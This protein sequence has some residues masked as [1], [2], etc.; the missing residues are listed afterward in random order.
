MSAISYEDVPFEPEYEDY[1]D[2]LSFSEPEDEPE[3]DL[4]IEDRRK[5]NE[6]KEILKVHPFLVRRP[7]KIMSHKHTDEQGWSSYG[8]H[9]KDSIGKIGIVVEVHNTVREAVRVEFPD[10]RDDIYW[11]YK[12]L[13][14]IAPKADDTPP[15]F[16]DPTNLII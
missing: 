2:E 4:N 16:F 8:S 14:L 10:V 13:E 15:V 3:N 12:D 11:H 1:E 5:Q 9:H 6:E 7:V